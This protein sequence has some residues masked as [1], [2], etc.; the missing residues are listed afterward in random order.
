MIPRVL[1]F[2]PGNADLQIGCL[3]ILYANQ[4]IGVPGETLQEKRGHRQDACATLIFPFS[5]KSV[6]SAYVEFTV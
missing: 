2:Q 3:K 4:E 1:P 6:F 5:E